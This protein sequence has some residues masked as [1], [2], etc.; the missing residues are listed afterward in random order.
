MDRA[1]TNTTLWH[2]VPLST[3]YY[4]YHIVVF[5]PAGRSS[6]RV[7]LRQG[8]NTDNKKSAR[9][10]TEQNPATRESHKAEPR[11]ETVKRVRKSL[12]R[13]QAELAA[14]L[15]I[16]VKAVQSYEQGWRR[17]PTRTVIQLLVLLDLQERSTEGQAPCWEIRGCA[18][19]LKQ[20]CAA[21]TMTQGRFCWFVGA[22]TCLGEE[23]QEDGEEKVLPCLA[24]PVVQRLLKGN[25]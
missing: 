9:T 1:S 25:A 2:I 22:K 17:V 10:M 11:S 6:A 12:G 18:P 24:C 8:E 16:S 20:Q 19:D 15:G 23:A 7:C 13:T 21:Y 3:V 14:A 5:Q 4:N